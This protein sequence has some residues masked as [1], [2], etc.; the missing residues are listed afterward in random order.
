MIDAIP[1]RAVGIPLRW[2]PAEVGPPRRQLE[3]GSHFER[4]NFR[5][6]GGADRDTAQL[7]RL[8]E[9]YRAVGFAGRGTRVRLG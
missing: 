7:A 4:Q 9:M 3:K 8:R 5:G 2:L 1:I 6:T